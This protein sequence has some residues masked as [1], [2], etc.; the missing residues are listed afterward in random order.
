[1]MKDLKPVEGKIC[2]YL[3]ARN[4][5]GMMEGGENPWYLLDDA[6]TICWCIISA[7]A[8]GPDNNLIGPKRCVEGRSC[9]VPPEPRTSGPR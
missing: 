9:F 7:G 1:M 8:A 4:P 3:R 5:Y 6:N 2:K